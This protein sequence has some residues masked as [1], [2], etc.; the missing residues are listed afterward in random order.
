MRELGIEIIT[1]AGLPAELGDLWVVEAIVDSNGGTNFSI[2]RLFN[3]LGTNHLQVCRGWSSG[4]VPVALC[5]TVDE[6][7]D[8]VEFLRRKQRALADLRSPE[9]V[10]CSARIGQ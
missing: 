9:A 10:A 4:Y 1:T 6:A 2:D 5:R 7:S 3:V 8:T